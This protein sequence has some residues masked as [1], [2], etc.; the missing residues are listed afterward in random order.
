MNAKSL[1]NLLTSSAMTAIA[2][3]ILTMPIKNV[4]AQNAMDQ[5]VVITLQTNPLLNPEAA[6]V[7]LQ[8]GMNLLRSDISDEAVASVTLFP[9][10]EGVSIVSEKMKLRDNDKYPRRW[11]CSTP[12]GEEPL[13]EILAGFNDQMGTN[14][15]VCPLC[16]MDRF[17]GED[18]IYGSLG[19]GPTIHNLFL[20]ADKVIDF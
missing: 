8:L 17:D 7:A 15:V 9:T 3:I 6:C 14:I 16:W 1:C 2:A 13:P 5:N 19:D 11:N 10:L 12:D 20:N 18:P 4:M